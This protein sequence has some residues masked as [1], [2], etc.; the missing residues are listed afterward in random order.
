MGG[1]IIFLALFPQNYIHWQQHFTMWKLE[2]F[3][4]ATDRGKYVRI[5]L[6]N[7][8]VGDEGTMCSRENEV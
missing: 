1:A 4:T 3:E 6:R 2:L 7:A 8:C 5:F